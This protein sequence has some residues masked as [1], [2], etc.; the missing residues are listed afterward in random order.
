MAS[1]CK[2][3][4]V[5]E[6]ISKIIKVSIY[7]NSYYIIVL[8]LLFL[9]LSEPATITTDG[10]EMNVLTAINPLLHTSHYRVRMGKIS[11]LK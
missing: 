6:F 2:L 11:I 5:N 1:L 7:L 9:L 4:F 10:R 3:N 8:Q